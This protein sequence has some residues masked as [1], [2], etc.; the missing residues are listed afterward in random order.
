[1]YSAAAFWAS[2]CAFV[3]SI[4]FWG[5]SREG[6]QCSV[7]EELQGESA[8]TQEGLREPC[9]FGGE[10]DGAWGSAVRGRG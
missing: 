3:C 2:A 8:V 1:M 7:V 5:R 9:V 10:G 4:G 6:W